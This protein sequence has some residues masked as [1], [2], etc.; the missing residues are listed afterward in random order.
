[1]KSCP[2]M[3]M[4]LRIPAET[5][6]KPHAL[7]VE[8]ENKKKKHSLK[9]LKVLLTTNNSPVYHCTFSDFDIM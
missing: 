1:M 3:L 7:A 2:V 4:E 9:V 5:E 8:I 6:K